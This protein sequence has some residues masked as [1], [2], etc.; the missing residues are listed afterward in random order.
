MIGK[1][2][3]D[4]DVQQYLRQWTFTAVEGA[5]GTCEI[6]IPNLGNFKVAEVSSHVLTH[7]RKIAENF[8]GNDKKVKDAVITVPAYFNNSQ[9]D[10]TKVAA[11]IAGLNVLRLINEPTA[12][13]MAANLHKVD[14][15]KNV[16]VFDFGGG[17]FDISILCVSEGVLDV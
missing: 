3:V 5:G 10:A 13:A 11:Q 15:E 12:A 16:L 7:L 2:F 8:V 14:D 6:A 4:E 1:A 17:T 9:K